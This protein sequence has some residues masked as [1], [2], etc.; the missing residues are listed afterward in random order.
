M[1]A[2]LQEALVRDGRSSRSGFLLKGLL[3]LWL[4][5]TA[6]L[7]APAAPVLAGL[8]FWLFV[9][10]IYASRVAL[11][12]AIRRAHDLGLADD[13]LRSPARQVEAGIQA[14]AF[15]MFVVAIQAAARG[16]LVFSLAM[17]ATAAAGVS[18]TL[19]G[20]L[21]VVHPL[22]TRIGLLETTGDGAAPDQTINALLAARP[23]EE[24]PRATKV[25]RPAPPASTPRPVVR[26]RRRAI[27]DWGS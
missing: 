23:A 2:E 26:K 21:K 6:L 13:Y 16:G 4:V 11:A 1:W 8:G 20:G 27:G 3:P 25:A 14:F 12:Q 9:L 15:V 10:A 17:A 24:R 5:L 22:A 7:A 19:L 18:A